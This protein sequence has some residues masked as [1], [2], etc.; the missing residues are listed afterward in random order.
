MPIIKKDLDDSQLNDLML[1]QWESIDQK[2][3]IEDPSEVIH[4]L[5]IKR[6]FAKT[7]LIA[8][9]ALLYD[10]VLINH[11]FNS[12]LNAAKFGTH[13]IDYFEIFSLIYHSKLNDNMKFLLFESFSISSYVLMNLDETAK[14]AKYSVLFSN[15]NNALMNISSLL[16]ARISIFPKILQ[17]FKLDYFKFTFTNFNLISNEILNNIK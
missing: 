5:N 13:T 16:S 8:F 2:W 1:K 7:A 9:R 11:L 3:N 6:F 4:T 12:L 10:K 17:F 15:D 14:L